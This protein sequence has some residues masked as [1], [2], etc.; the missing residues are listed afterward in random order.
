MSTAAY[1]SFSDRIA[2]LE[3]QAEGE[4][5]ES[6][7]RALPLEG[8]KKVL[9]VGSGSGVAARLLAQLM[10]DTVKVF[11]LDSSPEHI[12][13][14]QERARNQQLHNLEFISGDILDEDSL[15]G[16][17]NDFDLVYCR[18]LM[19]YMVPKKLDQF[20]LANMKRCIRPE[21]KVVCI[22]PDVNFGQERYPPPP[23]PLLTVLNELVDFYR[24]QEQIE[25]RCGVR[26]YD[27]MRRAGFSR[28]EVK[29][30]NGRILQGGHPRELAQHGAMDVEALIHPC[31]KRMGKTDLLTLAVRQ[32]RDY[33][34]RPD[35]FLYTPIFM[36][37]GT[38]EPSI[39]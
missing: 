30:V 3:L 8:V 6:M 9:E 11:G 25:W 14:A 5:V 20:C 2:A 23:Q 39:V 15:S 27:C 36:A 17:D 37:I 34:I 21:G 35:T 22:E 19:M 32:W 24:E 26:L 29:L 38:I 4:D 33:L 18:Y 16:L 28:V 10:G 13:Y 1:S 7:I 31:L 12:A